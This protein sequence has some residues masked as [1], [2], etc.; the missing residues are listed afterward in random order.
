M[1]AHNPKHCLVMRKYKIVDK[2]ENL[3]VIGRSG[4]LKD[5]L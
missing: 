2:E 4:F 1:F 5:N 3:G